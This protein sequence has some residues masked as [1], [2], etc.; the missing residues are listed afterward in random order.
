MRRVL[1]GVEA[2]MGSCL[3]CVERSLSRGVGGMEGVVGRVGGGMERGMLRGLRGI[4]RGLRG[5]LPDVEAGVR[6]VLPG[7]ERGMIGRLL[8]GQGAED[9]IERFVKGVVKRIG[10]RVER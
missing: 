8:T 7:V 1:P 4:E 5:G 10:E 6:R 3:S 9:R 2:L